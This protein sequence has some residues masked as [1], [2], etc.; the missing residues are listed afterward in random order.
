MP[1]NQGTVPHQSLFSL[2]CRKRKQ[3]SKRALSFS[4]A[5]FIFGIL[6]LVAIT[7]SA[8]RPYL[9]PAYSLPSV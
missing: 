1:A 5:D 9:V 8:A 4:E 3:S 2:F 7:F 6:P